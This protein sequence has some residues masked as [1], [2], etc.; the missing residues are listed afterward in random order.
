MGTALQFD[1]SNCHYD[2]EGGRFLS[3]DPIGF[4]SGDLNLYRYVGNNSVNYIDPYGL[5]TYQCSRP[6]EPWNGI[7]IPDHGYLCVVT[8]Y[9]FQCAGLV[10][11]GD[12]APILEPGP[13]HLQS[14]SPPGSEGVSCNK[15]TN[16]PNEKHTNCVDKCV[17]QAFLDDVSID[18][19]AAIP[20]I[21]RNCNTYAGQ[22]VKD[23][24]SAC[25]RH[26]NK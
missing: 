12:K 26:K 1:F 10:P 4:N 11:T 14:E 19:Y 2:P 25:M 6:S 18:D 15:I 13:G 16:D 20:W 3:I 7:P 17:K 24:L 22:T 9:G 5:D 8:K 21:G 23:C